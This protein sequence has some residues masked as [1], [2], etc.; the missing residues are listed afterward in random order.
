[1]LPLLELRM[2]CYRI[3]D[4]VVKQPIAYNFLS[5]LRP[6]FIFLGIKGAT[7]IKTVCVSQSAGQNKKKTYSIRTQLK[8]DHCHFRLK[9]CVCHRYKQ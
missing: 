5:L 6:S 8:K 3:M 7:F 9:K 2:L 1:M 4:A